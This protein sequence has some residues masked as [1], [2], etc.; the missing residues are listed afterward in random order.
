MLRRIRTL[1]AEARPDQ[2][3]VIVASLYNRRYVDGMLRATVQTL[4]RAGAARVEVVRVPGAFEIPIVASTLARN[5]TGRPAAIICLGVIM[6]GET[7]HADY[8]GETVSRAL[9][10]IQLTDGVPV[11]HEVLLLENHAQARV[12]CLDKQHNR[13]IEAALTAI[14]MANLMEDLAAGR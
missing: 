8:I 11:V 2:R 6:R 12:R 7:V 4:R 9:M 10:Q 14:R 13:G 1:K 3:F 5:A